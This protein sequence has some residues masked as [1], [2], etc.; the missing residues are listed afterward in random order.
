MTSRS[1][2]PRRL[3][4]LSLVALIGVVLGATV[5]AAPAFAQG[6]GAGYHSGLGDLGA[7]RAN[8]GSQVYCLQLTN[9]RTAG[10]HATDGGTYGQWGADPNANARVNFVLTRYGQSSDNNTAAA[11]AMYVWDQLDNADYNS[12]GMSGDIYYV[13]RAPSAQQNAILS[14]LKGFRS[15]AA[16][17]TAGT[18]GQ[19]QMSFYIDP[20]NNYEGTL[21]V[22]GVGSGTG[23]ITLNNGIFTS[24]G[25]NQFSGAGNGTLTVRGVPPQGVTDYRIS[26]TGSF[27]DPDSYAGEVKIYNIIGGGQA[28]AAAGEHAAFQL[29]ANDPFDRSTTF[30]PVLSTTA[31]SAFIKKGDSFSDAVTFSTGA[32]SNGVNNDWPKFVDGT[33]YEVTA[34]ATIYGPLAQEPERAATPPAGTPVAGTASVT[35]G[36]TG[37]TTYT[38]ISDPGSVATGAGFYSWVWTIGYDDQSAVTQLYLPA[39]YSFVD[40]FG[41]A[42]ESQIVAPAIASKADPTGQ[43]GIAAHDVAI[44]TGPVFTGAQVGFD[45]YLQ[46]A[47]TSTTTPVCLPRNRVF[48]SALQ[49]VTAAGEYTSPDAQLPL[50]TIFWVVTLYDAGGDIAAQAPCGDTDETSVISQ[51]AVASIATST[52]LPGDAVRDTALLTG[53][54]IPG[55]AIS[56]AAYSAPEAG[57]AAVCDASTQVYHSDPQGLAAGVVTSAVVAGT[58]TSFGKVGTYLWVAT[59]TNSAGQIVAQGV[60]GDAAETTHV[61]PPELAS[62]GLDEGDVRGWGAGAAGGILAGLLLLAWPVVRRRTLAPSPSR[63]AVGRR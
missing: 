58:S 54:I 46:P 23:T 41:Q 36:V 57:S 16:G 17:I 44:I 60:C 21:V 9:E 47:S 30:Q 37:P 8:D 18:A 33:F 39:G 7:Y 53:T 14:I 26:A 42:A 10:N 1:S 22:D 55:D 3:A 61:T 27:Y 15:S 62:T 34:K 25:T 11:V 40:G 49:P 12:H 35:T 13:G 56:F 38:V 4:F 24:T 5:D 50:G 2:R 48:S 19:G 6:T 52:A 28:V 31:S 59:V 29:T 20:T 51:L 63:A 43:L 32:D 45:A